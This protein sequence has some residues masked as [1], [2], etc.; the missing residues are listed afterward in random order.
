M[1]KAAALVAVVGFMGLAGGSGAL[2]AGMDHAPD[3]ARAVINMLG[4]NAVSSEELSHQQARGIKLTKALSDGA[5]LGN[6]VGPGSVTGAITN[7]NSINNNVG[8]TTVFQ[9]S[10]N[11][12]LFQSSTSIYISIR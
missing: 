9:N 3:G 1:G 5:V 11:N 12:S 8:I 10:G 4:G 2:A 6:S 7:S